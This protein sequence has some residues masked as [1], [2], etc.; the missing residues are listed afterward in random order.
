MSAPHTPLATTDTRTQP[1]P[2]D[3][4]GTSTGRSGPPRGSVTA[5]AVLLSV[6]PVRG[7]R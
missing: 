5:M 2:G 7:V 1:G 4:T 3:S 6:P